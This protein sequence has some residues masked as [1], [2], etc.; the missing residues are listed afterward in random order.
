MDLTT[1]HP[2]N[3]S[4]S[5]LM[6]ELERNLIEKNS[7]VEGMENGIFFD[8]KIEKILDEPN[9]GRVGLKTASGAFRE[10]DAVLGC[11]GV[12]G[13]TR[14]A[15]GIEVSGHKKLRNFLNIH[16][17]S[18]KLAEKLLENRKNAMLHFVMNSE[19]LGCLINYS[20][21]DGVFVF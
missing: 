18:K 5:V 1:Q 9:G 4:Q 20:Y 16:F 2:V 8:E 11:D 7:I 14:K 15:A 12:H 6:E 21:N 3:I 13:I 19:V 10:Y 17:E